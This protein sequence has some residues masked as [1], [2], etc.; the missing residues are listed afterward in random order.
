MD[1]HF[2]IETEYGI[3]RD[4][5]AELDVVEE[6]IAL[7]RSYG[8][9]GAAMLWDYRLEDPHRDARGFRVDELR[10]DTDEA[11]YTERDAARPL[12]FREIKSDVVLANGARFYNDHA[13]PEYS[14]PE[15][16]TLREVVAHDKAG[17]RIL[18]ECALRRNATLPEAEP[19]RLYKN[20]TD[21]I[22]HSFGCH[23]NYLLPR[24]V[25]WEALVAGV[26]PFLVTRQIFA[27]AGKLGV[28][29][30]GAGVEPGV[31]QI[32]QRADFFSVIVSVDTMNRR[33]I[34]NSRDEPHAN[35]GRHRRFHCIVGDANLSEVATALKLG[36]T[37]LVLELIS[38]GHAPRL[39]LANPVAALRAVSRDTAL[40]TEV[41]LAGGGTISAI[42]IQRAY[43]AAAQRYADGDD[44]ETAW[45]L[46]EWE[47]VLN[48]LER[49]PMRCA[50]RLDWVAKKALLEH[51]REE[52]R[53]EW[54]SPW[55]QSLD[56]EYHN[57]DPEAG[58]YHGLLNACAIR[59]FVSDADVEAA[60]TGPPAATRAFFRG[61]AVARFAGQ[62][63]S[64]QWDE[65][66]FNTAT[67]PRTVR[68][69]PELAAHWNARMRAAQSVEGLFIS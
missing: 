10:Q 47:A 65:V 63:A 37:A 66:V 56:L 49:D 16:S 2:G 35:A 54:D 1:A 60:L 22:G 32:S 42:E 34:V 44:E 50:D 7:V 5:V 24:A 69:E 25:P 4:G 55:L 15:C 67:G 8:A 19:V 39:E 6:S 30:E 36:T 27:G 33:P 9:E 57:L 21:F 64:L 61:Q 13:H 12:S 59:R 53:L 38:Q 23:D 20:N 68:L 28:E 41:P 26:L 11:N 45:V 29:R 18:H 31:Y 3:T 46:E 51:F 58:L 48:D 62:I 40:R 14:T 52:E 17:E 43:L